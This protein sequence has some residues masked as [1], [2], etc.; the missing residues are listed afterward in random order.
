MGDC[1]KR[2][3]Q[4][5]AMSS[6]S[7]WSYDSSGD[8]DMDG[9]PDDLENQLARRFV[10]NL[11]LRSTPVAASGPNG[12]RG[13]L[14]S[15]GS[16]SA[17]GDWQFVVRPAIGYSDQTD[18]YFWNDN[19]GQWEVASS[20]GPVH[21]CL[22][23]ECLEITYVIPYNWDLG[24][25]EILNSNDHRGDSEMYSVLVARKDPL[26]KVAGADVAPRWNAPWSTAKYQASA[27]LGYAEFGTAHTCDFGDSTSFRFHVF[28]P[29]YDGVT[30]LWVSQAKH[31]NYFSRGAC[32]HGAFYTDTCDD[33]DFQL[34]FAN[35][36]GGGRGPLRNAGEESCHSH[37]T[38]DHET[39]YPGETSYQAPYGTYDVW[40]DRPFGDDDVGR[41]LALLRA[42]TVRWWVTRPWDQPYTCWAHASLPSAPPPPPPPLP[43]DCPMNSQCCA[44][45]A[46]G[47]CI[48]CVPLDAACP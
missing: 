12:D 10:P 14:Y 41:P 38:I 17:P 16:W 29:S 7:G 33:N 11:W 19:T 21:Q 26:V 30:S 34:I 22:D 2:C 8:A 15:G 23:T 47:H 25:G 45:G 36:F 48:Q 31:A 35:Q 4:G 1:D 9:I 6:C 32:D 20:T 5:G 46:D 24:T 42:G 27:W 43:S 28:D 39:L 37:P 3:M 13:Q 18:S 44:T 40:S